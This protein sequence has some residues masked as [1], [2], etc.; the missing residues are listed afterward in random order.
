MRMSVTKFEDFKAVFFDFDGVVGDTY[1]DGYAAWTHALSPYNIPFDI[2]E[3]ASLEGHKAMEVAAILV[4]RHK[5]DA[6][7]V[8]AIVEAKD[9]YYESHNSFQ[10]MPHV[11]ELLRF[12][13]QKEVLLGLVTGARARRVFLPPSAPILE[14][15]DVVITAEDVVHGKPSPEPYLVAAD[16]L[17]VAPSN[18]IVIENAPLGV[19]SAKAAGMKCIALTSTLPEDYLKSADLIVSSL[20]DVITLWSNGTLFNT[21]ENS[22]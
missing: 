8:P 1:R 9:L 4:E 13:K 18:C 15:F 16:R 12:F 5:L 22:A 11:L 19:R 10:P 21:I 6:S 14:N 20:S 3:Y 17:K 7:L 2:I